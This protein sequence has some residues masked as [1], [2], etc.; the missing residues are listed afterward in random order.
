MRRGYI[1]LNTCKKHTSK[2]SIDALNRYKNT[3]I[4][5]L[6]FAILSLILISCFLWL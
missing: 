6:L 1:F 4:G 5:C 2:H 3:G